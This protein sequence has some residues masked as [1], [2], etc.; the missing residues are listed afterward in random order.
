MEQKEIEK[1][2]FLYLCGKRDRALLCGREK[3]TLSDLDRLTYITD[4]LKLEAYNLELW[5][6]Y[7]GQFQEQFRM[8]S[9]LYDEDY[10]FI[11]YDKSEYDYNQQGQWLLDFCKNAPGKEQKN[12]LKNMIE[13]FCDEKSE[14][15]HR[16]KNIEKGM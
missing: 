4:F 6:Q 1:F 13:Q 15:E 11:S 12:Y 10:N 16:E 14:L 9:R 7:A 3:M 8:L 5:N 2:A